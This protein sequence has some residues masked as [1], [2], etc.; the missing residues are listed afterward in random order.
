[1]AL[2]AHCFITVGQRIMRASNKISP[3]L[4][5]SLL[6]STQKRLCFIS[7]SSYA[8]KMN[9]LAAI[10]LAAMPSLLHLDRIADI[11]LRLWRSCFLRLARHSRGSYFIYRRLKGR[12]L[13]FSA[14]MWSPPASKHAH[15]Q[16]WISN[17]WPVE[18]AEAK[19]D[20][21]PFQGKSQ[22]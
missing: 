12:L 13:T 9:W 8:S 22:A 6:P 7:T 15:T 1:M 16:R 10:R 5:L 19:T 20:A 2:K 21:K 18:A 17:W 14:V 3:L 4:S 11:I